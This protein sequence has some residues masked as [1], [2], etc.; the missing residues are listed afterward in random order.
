MW[1]RRAPSPAGNFV[2][3]TRQAPRFS[4]VYP[5]DNWVCPAEIESV[6][7]HSS[8]DYQLAK[9]IAKTVSTRRAELGLSQYELARR[10]ELDRTTVQAI[11][12]GKTDL[13]NNR[14]ANPKILTLLHLAEALE[15]SIDDLLEGVEE[16]FAGREDRRAPG[17]Y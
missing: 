9:Q 16:T 15:M 12:V 7:D 6:S 3:A 13:K 2:F 8:I 14:N 1:P 17:M 11:E 4:W 5:A 10:A